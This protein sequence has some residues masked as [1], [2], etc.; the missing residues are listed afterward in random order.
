[1]PSTAEKMWKQLNLTH[2]ISTA[3][4]ETETRWGGLRPGTKICKGPAL[5]PR[6]ETDKTQ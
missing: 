5:F 3:S 4:L 6:I 2:D 1:M